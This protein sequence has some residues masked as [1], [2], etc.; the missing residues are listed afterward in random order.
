LASAVVAVV[1]ASGL[2]ASS[3]EIHVVFWIPEKEMG[4]MCGEEECSCGCVAQQVKVN[5]VGAQ[6]NENMNGE[7]GENGNERE[8]ER[9]NESRG[10]R[11]DKREDK[12]GGGAEA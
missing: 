6:G 2:D 1:L 8:T 5:L 3:V 11:E 10:E 4:T 12:S 7:E 9:K